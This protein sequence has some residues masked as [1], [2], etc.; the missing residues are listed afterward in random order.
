MNIKRS[1][2]KVPT[3]SKFAEGIIFKDHFNEDELIRVQT[4]AS[5]LPQEH[6][7]MVKAVK[8]DYLDTD[9]HIQPDNTIVLGEAVWWTGVLTHEIGHA[10]EQHYE[11]QAEGPWPHLRFGQ[12]YRDLAYAAGLAFSTF[13][14][15][16]EKKDGLDMPLYKGFPTKYSMANHS[17]LF[18]ESYEMY[19]MMPRILFK[20]NPRIYAYLKND[21]FGGIEYIDT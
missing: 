15:H 12:I 9:A 7:N 6:L 19:V 16:Y 17:E 2:K 1:A 11:R 20:R 8:Q 3:N 4:E 14:E 21:I 5:V 13:K 10:V 18:A